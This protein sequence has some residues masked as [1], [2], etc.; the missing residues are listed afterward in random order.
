MRGAWRQFQGDGGST[1]FKWRAT[2]PALRTAWRFDAGDTIA[3][4]PV[5]DPEGVVYLAS[6]RGTLI[7]VGPGGSERWRRDYHL[8]VV[9]APAVAADGTI[10]FI[11]CQRRDDEDDRFPLR[12]FVVKTSGTG[13][14]LWT[15]PLPDEGYA[16]NAVKLLERQDGAHVVVSFVRRGF[17]GPAGEL[18]VL[19]PDGGV[20]ARSGELQCPWP[21]SASGPLSGFFRRVGQAAK[22]FWEG[23][24]T[25]P[26][27]E[28]DTSGLPLFPYLI[29]P[30]PAVTDAPNLTAEG[31]ALIAMADSLCNL[32]VFRYDGTR[33]ERLWRAQHALGLAHGSP[34]VTRFGHLV[35]GDDDGL[36]RAFEV[37]T[38]RLVWSYEA[39]EPALGTPASL[40]QPIY[41]PTRQNLHV[42]DA[43]RG[44]Q[45]ARV[46]LRENREFEFHPR[47][48]PAVSLGHVHVAAPL[49]L[50]SVTVGEWTR[51]AHDTS[52]SL[53]PLGPS[54][55]IGPDGELY[56]VHGYRELWAYAPPS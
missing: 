31:T 29:E 16:T 11:A 19:G 24:K 2:A 8:E 10:H 18:L 21:V 40:N 55:A 42:L 4:S 51:R 44:R 53:S 47:T 20:R 13:D 5:V 34:L 15:F 39:G 37:E 48:G 35:I 46:R 30:T 43:N 14:H 33:L 12:S 25:F 28:F 22:F 36:V 9:A 45:I 26:N 54:P 1:G 7:A 38:G 41:V 56:A 32:I 49:G 6:L 17:G 27:Y 52:Y 3:A 23:I 50:T